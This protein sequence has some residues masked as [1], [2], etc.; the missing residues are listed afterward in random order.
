M[1]LSHKIRYFVDQFLSKG[2]FAIVM[3]LSIV[4]FTA[5]IL[6]GLLSYFFSGGETTVFETLWISLMQTLDAGN[7][8][9]VDGSIWYVLL[10]TVATIV[11]IFI[12]SMLISVLSNGFQK[13]LENMQKGTSLV[14]E[15]GHTLLL[16]WNANI[17]IIVSEILVANESVKHPVIVILSETDTRSVIDELKAT[18][19]DFKNTKIIVRCGEIHLKDNL[20]MCAIAYARS[21]IIAENDDVANIKCLLGISQTAFFAPEANGHVTAIF[22]DK[23]NLNAAKRMC[24]NHLEAILLSDTMNRITAQ[25]CLQPGLSF[26]YKELL[27]FE[28]NEFYFYQDS[29]LANMTMKEVLCLFPNAAVCGLFHNDLPKI[30]P[31]MNTVIADNDKLIIICED[32]DKAILNNNHENR[33]QDQIIKMPHKASRS[34]RKIL[35]IGFN[36]NLLSVIR[37]MCP[38]IMAESNLVFLV[39]EDTDPILL[40]TTLK[41]CEVGFKITKGI[42]YS[43][44][45]LMRLDYRELD[46]IVVVA[47]YPLDGER[48]DS[49][50]L[51]TIMHLKNIL[52]EKMLDIPIIIEIERIQNEPV[53]QY[54]S[55]NDFIVSNVLSNKMLCQIA[56]NR[57]LNAVFSELLDEAGSEIYLKPAKQYVKLDEPVDFYTVVDSASLKGETAIGYRLKRISQDGG[58]FINPNK[59]DLIVFSSGDCVV[60]LAED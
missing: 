31:P 4:T 60:I 15:K 24:G 27:D 59:D 28:G 58:V 30:N 18:V 49:E 52:E 44:D 47:N 13:K 42:T 11:G 43:N 5:V 55:I 25:T 6:I 56:E 16:G 39:P 14:I 46:T 8:S 22:S 21:V 29:R 20:E 17:P 32:D 54:A 36:P 12:T 35:F 33:F 37:E 38:Y 19:K 10:M 23:Q 45:V 7:L 34:Y 26:I 41:H 53:L 51:L 48:S 3:M 9:N 2:T 40:E 1:K 57:H 50:T